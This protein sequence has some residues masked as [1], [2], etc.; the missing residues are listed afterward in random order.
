VLKGDDGVIVNEPLKMASLFNECFCKAFINDDLHT[1]WDSSSYISNSLSSVSFS[2][3]VIFSNIKKMKNSQTVSPDGFSPHT[4]KLLDSVL[5]L[6]I[7]RLFEYFLSC[8]FVPASWKISRIT[9][10]FKKGV[11]SNPS[12]YRPISNTSIFCR[13]MERII[14]DQISV[15]LENNHLLSPSQHGFHKG[16]S[17]ASNL[18][19]CVTEWIF[20]LDSGNSIDVAFIDLRRA[21]DSVVYSKLFFK[22]SRIGIGGDLMGWI[23]QY[24][25]NRWQCTSIEG[26]SSPLLR[27]ISGV[28]QGSVLGPLLFIIFINDLPDYLIS[29]HSL[30]LSPVKLFADDLKM[31][32]TK[33]SLA[34]AFHF[35]ALLNTILDWCRIWQL[36]INVEKCQILHLGKLNGRY[37]YGLN[38]LEIPNPPLVN[39]LGLL[40][41]ES[42]SFSKHIAN[43]V[44]KARS[45]CGVFL[46]TF[47]SRDKTVMK[48]FFTTYVRPTLEYCSVI[49][50]PLS[51]GDINALEGV[52]RY[53]TNKIPGCTFLP[54]RQRL[55]I[56]SL[57][58]LQHRR[59]VSDISCLHSI[60]SGSLVVSLA[61]FLSH[62]PPSKTR[63]HDLRIIRPIL[64]L[65]HSNQNFITRIVPCWNTLPFDVLS[66]TSRD[67]FRRRISKYLTDPHR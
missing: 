43:I 28:P 29:K 56:L 20:S 33:N 58:S 8:K 1:F 60:I 9:P 62:I 42:L 23:V 63:G 48:T 44:S 12:N 16:N 51:Q 55:L 46:K 31:F 67:S 54:Y 41:D 30:L 57:D 32:K 37:S 52:Q 34:D 50:N 4:V 35:Q 5:A 65:V 66:S 7:A 64:R 53:F 61:P 14:F 18:L 36:T 2:P 21:F 40:V 39:D 47:I 13:I 24:L 27:V 38:N 19:E 59:A 49:W 25:T 3:S 26:I 45:R 22:L 17:T 6:P 10:L 15:Y 11:R